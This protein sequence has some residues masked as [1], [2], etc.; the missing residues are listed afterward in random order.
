MFWQN[1]TIETH[2]H[3]RHI[4]MNWVLDHDDDHHGDHGVHGNGGDA[5]DGQI[6]QSRY[7][8]WQAYPPID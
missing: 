7:Y 3:H 4:L 6:G 1:V 2:R 8:G 5:R